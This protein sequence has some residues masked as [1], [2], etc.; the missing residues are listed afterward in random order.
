[1]GIDIGGCKK[2]H[3]ERFY[4]VRSI[5]NRFDPIGL[6]KIGWPEHEYDWQVCQ[7]LDGLDDTVTIEQ[8]QELIYDA[9]FDLFD[10]GAGKKE[11]YRLLAQTIKDWKEK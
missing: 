2:R 3:G 7:I 9:F 5:V 8:I 4:E 1:M 6:L 11:N 10:E